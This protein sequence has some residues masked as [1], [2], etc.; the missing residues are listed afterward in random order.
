MKVWKIFLA[1]G[2]SA[3]LIGIVVFLVGLGLNGWSTQ[4]KYEIK[5]Y[6]STEENTVLDLNLSAGEMYV[7]FYDGDV[8]EVEYPDSYQYGYYVDELNGKLSVRP[9]TS[10]FSWFGW[11]RVPSVVVRIPTGKVMELNVDISAGKVEVAEGEFTSVKTHMSAGL[12][13]LGDIKCGK[14]VSHLS[15]GKLN[16]NSLECTDFDLRLSAGAASVGRTK[17]DKFDVDLSAGSVNLTVAGKKSEY[18][19]T[20]DKSAGSCSVSDQTGTD[21]NKRIDVDLSAGSVNVSFTD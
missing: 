19:I 6:H 4:A 11:N 5:T 14:F 10:F 2:I 16:V 12:T 9:R 15:A 3:L 8:I 17:C 20:V 13:N 21:A 18:T 7:G 1:I